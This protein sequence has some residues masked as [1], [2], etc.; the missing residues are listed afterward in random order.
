MPLLTAA[1]RHGMMPAEQ[2]D[3]CYQKQ[4]TEGRPEIGARRRAIA[5]ERLRGPVVGIRDGA[6]RAIRA[7]SPRGPPEKACERAPVLRVGHGVILHRV[8]FTQ[9]CCCRIVAKQAAIVGRHLRDGL[10]AIGIQR[11]ARG[12]W[13]V[14]IGAKSDLQPAA[15]GRL[16]LRRQFLIVCS[17]DFALRPQ[18]EY[19]R[20]FAM[21][22][23]GAPVRRNVST[24]SPYRA[25]FHATHRL[26]D[27]AALLNVGSR[28]GQ[29]ALR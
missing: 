4:Y 27:L 19:G 1:V 17:A 18:V 25:Q 21:Q 13:V 15:I 23:I 24:V 3:A 26:P 16:L 29:I 6:A 2:C 10:G 12:G 7:G 11:D 28:E 5:D 20:G 14:R 22:P 8:R 9:A